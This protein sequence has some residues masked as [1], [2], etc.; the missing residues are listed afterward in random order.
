MFAIVSVAG[1]SKLLNH[2]G[3]VARFEKSVVPN[4]LLLVDNFLL[5]IC[6]W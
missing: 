6:I 4:I 2:M 1:P 3:A 5:I